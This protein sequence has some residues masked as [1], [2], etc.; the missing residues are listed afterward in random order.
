MVSACLVGMVERGH[1]VVVAIGSSVTEAAPPVGMTPYVVAK[2]ALTSYMKCLAVEFGP[3]GIR[4]NVVAPGMTQTAL[5]ATMPSRLRKVS[6]A[7]T[8]TRRL[9]KPTD[10]AG[11]VSYLV[12]DSASHVNGH[13]LLVSGGN[14]I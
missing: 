13:T 7:Q 4:A 12:S 1:G 2:A 9:A 5:L 8:P 10:V 11:A 14:P 3:K 6:A